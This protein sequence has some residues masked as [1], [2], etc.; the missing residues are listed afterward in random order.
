M[1]S[2]MTQPPSDGAGRILAAVL[3]H[4]PAER[5]AFLATACGEDA[6]L[7]AEMRDLLAAHEAAPAGFLDAP[8]VANNLDVTFKHDPRLMPARQSAT[9]REGERI[10]RYKLLQQIGEGGFGSVWMAE[11]MEQTAAAR[12]SKTPSGQ[13]C[14]SVFKNPAGESAGHLIE[15]AGLKGTRIGGAE[16]AQKHGNYIVNLG[17]ASSDDVLRLIDLARERVQ[18]IFGIELALEVRLLGGVER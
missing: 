17:A 4:D 11:Q 3:D 12:R 13:S 18:H 2:S 10:G 9:E 14:G 15:Q 8:A 16:I 1:N 5:V 6:A 7:L